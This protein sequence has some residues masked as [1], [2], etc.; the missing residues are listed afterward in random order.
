VVAADQI[1]VP[2]QHGLGAHEQPDLAQC[3]AGESVQQRG[4]QGPVGRGELDLLA[5]Q[6]PLQNRDLVPQG[7][8]LHVL[9]PVADAQQP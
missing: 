5:V 7:E 2:A 4:E 6:L 8:D 9:G 3:G 1:A